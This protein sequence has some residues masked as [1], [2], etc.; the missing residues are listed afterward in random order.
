M[1][2]LALLLACML[3]LSPAYAQGGEE[4][5]APE[6][7]QESTDQAPSLSRW[8]ARTQARRT[9][10]HASTVRD[11][12][13]VHEDGVGRVWFFSWNSEA[14][15]RTAMEQGQ[16]PLFTLSDRRRVPLDTQVLEVD[17][18]RLEIWYAHRGYF[19]AQVTGWEVREVRPKPALNGVRPKLLQR[20][21]MVHVVGHVELGPETLIESVTIHGL[22]GLARTAVLPIERAQAELLG[23]RFDLNA[24]EGLASTVVIELQNR[25][26]ARATAT[27][28]I[29]AIPEERR[30]EVTVDVNPGPVCVFGEVRVEGL[31]EVPEDVVL[32]RITIQAGKRFE[33]TELSTTHAAI[34]AM[35]TFSA[36][37]VRPDLSAEGQVIPIT[38]VV[39]ET[40][41]RELLVG[42]GGAGGGGALELRARARFEH[43]N[44]VNRMLQTKV[45]ITGGY[46]VFPSDV[47]TSADLNAN[48]ESLRAGAFAELQASLYYPRMF[49][50]RNWSARP[51]AGLELARERSSAYKSIAFSPAVA[52][53][54]S[55]RLVLTPSYNYKYIWDLDYVD[56]I[57]AEIDYLACP[58]DRTQDC[59]YNLQYVQLRVVSDRR[60]P[61]LQ[62]THGSYAEVG[63]SSAGFGVLGD[64][65]FVRTTV[66]LRHYQQVL[67]LERR[68]VLAAR[69]G[70]GLAQAYGSDTD[71]AQVPLPERFTLGGSTSVRGF[72]EDLLGPR[73]CYS[74]ATDA[75]IPNCSTPLKRADV[76][77]T[78]SGGQAMT[79]GSLE[80]RVRV[81][82][83]TDV[84]VFS[85]I[86]GNWASLQDVSL[87]GLQPTAGLGVRI[88]TPAGPL[89]LDFAYRLLNDP[90]YRL[91]RRY[92]VYLSIQ[93]AF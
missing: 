48:L 24:P 13:F 66:D 67:L 75:R 49:G 31:S 77:F 88:G 23:S 68:V 84:V 29:V 71:R 8:W 44:V 22:E 50:Q 4:P 83:G 59:T 33:P 90:Q 21:P 61:L 85:D 86:G 14:A 32:D 55:R 52:W 46:K 72:A 26:Y 79:Y 69:V 34:F 57:P 41:F 56:A 20:G 81:S 80:A 62:P 53:A 82:T 70:G 16:S 18:Y 89:R 51:T 47:D 35:G 54:P 15:V 78:P 73:E 45:D 38:I 76:N 19:D 37:Q 36:V 5:K 63:V 43:R 12:S 93:E 3:G 7:A 10:A 74:R 1:P 92:G 65:D 42:G 9:L 58:D 40:N 28:E 25:G 60:A 64:F 6:S 39:T 11:I 87:G 91:D 17:A 27:T 2:W 30:V